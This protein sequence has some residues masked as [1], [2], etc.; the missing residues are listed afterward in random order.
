MHVV[1]LC[2][3][4]HTCKHRV[5]LILNSGIALPILMQAEAILQS[6]SVCI[7]KQKQNFT[8]S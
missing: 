2:Q 4:M 5:D 1:K 7:L 3:C 6:G 8:L